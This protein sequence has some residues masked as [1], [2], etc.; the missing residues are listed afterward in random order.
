MPNISWMSLELESHHG[1]RERGHFESTPILAP[2]DERGS[3]DATSIVHPKNDQ[4][5]VAHTTVRYSRHTT[6]QDV[7]SKKAQRKRRRQYGLTTCSFPKDKRD[8]KEGRKEGKFMYFIH[9]F[10]PFFVMCSVARRARWDL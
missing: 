6:F 4:A 3:F 7:N 9:S 8:R 1:H 5:Y 2:S 10:A